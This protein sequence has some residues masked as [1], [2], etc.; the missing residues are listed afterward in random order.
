LICRDLADV[1]A[2]QKTLEEVGLFGSVVQ[3]LCVCLKVKV[4]FEMSG[5]GFFLWFLFIAGN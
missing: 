2:E 4:V 3:F 5:N 1:E